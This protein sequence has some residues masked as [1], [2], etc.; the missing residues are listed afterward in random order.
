M[1]GVTGDITET[2]QRERQLDTARAEAI[3]AH[4]DVEQAREI[5]Q[6]VLDNMTDGVTLWDKDFRWRF[7]NRRHMESWGYTPGDA[8]TRRHPADEMIR[9]QLTRGAYGQNVER[10]RQQASPRSP[11]ASCKPGGNRYTPAHRGRPLHRVQLQAA[12]RRQ[13]ARRLP[14]HHRAEGARGGARGRQ[15]EPPKRARND[16]E[17]TREIMQTVLD[18][19]SD[20]VMLFDKDMRWQ[21]TNRQLMEFQRF[22]PETWRSPG[23]VGARHPARS[24]RGAATSARSRNRTSTRRS[25]SGSLIMR[26]GARYERRTA[27]GRY[28]E[29]T[30]KPLE[31]GGL[32]AIYRDITRPE[33]TRG[34]ARGRQGGRPKPRAS[35]PRSRASRR[36]RR[37]RNCRR[38]STT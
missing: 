35:R 28:I 30:F 9:F 36:C 34:S 17:R 16:V 15:G 24:R 25:T 22:T 6:T 19:M 4:R 10:H 26:A 27:S 2:R 33:G 12:R 37:A 13:P 18:N 23:V 1:V 3:A 11:S 14:R 31:D 20:G 5:M 8:P 29:F 7:S 21:F 38:S 32:L